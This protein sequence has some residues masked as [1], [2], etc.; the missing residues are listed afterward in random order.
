[1]ARKTVPPAFAL[2]L[3]VLGFSTFAPAEGTRTWEQSKFEELTKGT[4][5]GIALRSAGGLELAPAF[6]AIATTPS[7]YLWSIASDSAGNIYAAAGSPARVYRI[8]PDGQ[9]T[10]IFEAPE[11]QVQSLAVDRAGIVYAATAPDGKVYR[12]EPPRSEPAKGAKTDAKTPWNWRPYFDPAAKYIWDIVVDDAGTLYIATGDHGE[13]YKVGADGQHSLFFKS[14]EVHIRVLALDATGNLIAGS[15]GSGL[16]YRIAP[17]GE[18]FVLYSAPKKEIT[19]LAIDRAGNIYAAAAGDKRTGTAPAQTS[20]SLVAPAPS[21]PAAG[22]GTITIPA[23]AAAG[24]P[25]TPFPAPGVGVTGGSEIY[26]IAPDGAPSRL[27]SSH[28]DLVYALGFDQRGRLLA[29]TGNR[30]HIFAINGV[31][32]FTDLIKASATQ[33]TAFAAAPGG[34][35]Y[36]SS[37]NLGKI[38]VLGPGLEREGTYESDVFDAHVFSLWGRA[39]LRSSGE[40]GAGSGANSNIELYARSGNVDNPDRNWS[41][42]TRVDWTSGAELNVPPARFVQWKTVLHAGN[43]APRV[44]SVLLNYLPKNV[45]P[46]IDEIVVQTGYHYQSVPHVTGNEGSG[47]GPS[48]Y[49]APPP[50]VR[51]RDSIGI[52]WSAHDDNDDQLVYAVYY[53]GDAEARWLLLKAN[54]SDRY[55]SFDASLLP[56]G[57][58][59]VKVIASDAP[60]HSPGEALYAERV[61]ERFEVDSTAPVIDRLAAAMDGK[62]I[63]VRFRAGDSFSVIKRAEYSLDGGD[64]QFVEP[65]GQLSDARTEDYDFRVTVPPAETGPTPMADNTAN[66]HV[67][68]VRAYDRFD[69]L[70]TAKVVVRGR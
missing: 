43:A 49:E 54:L 34:G 48:R 52:R 69:N 58:Y 66:D 18:A 31:D 35:L 39:R 9:S 45:A 42:W 15:D 16:V 7:T 22:G 2:I 13:I 68:V 20:I 62:Q 44:D 10:A 65:V 57:G 30:G 1:M 63:H 61:S 47:Q 8:A 19:A 5:N 64:W 3:A 37:S 36:A 23:A 38:F 40:P 46:E 12:L 25:A 53:R 59:T 24:A 56:D 21:I 32:D 60:S 28:E 51:D 26:R 11:L 70:A 67:V 17:N 29:G 27:W 14:D 6:K 55:Y 50:A 33:I 41:K 4:A